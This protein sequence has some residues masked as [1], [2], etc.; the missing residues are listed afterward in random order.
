MSSTAA[1]PWVLEHRL[2]IRTQTETRPGPRDATT[3]DRWAEHRSTGLALVACN[4][5]WATGWVPP[6]DLPSFADL[7][8]DHG[9]T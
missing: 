6:G 4:C 8:R 1:G 2:T 7:T 5:G 3:G 9:G